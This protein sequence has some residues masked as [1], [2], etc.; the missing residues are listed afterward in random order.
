MRL[1]VTR[2]QPDG[3]R[4]A[5]LLR[6]QGHAVEIAPALRTEPVAARFGRG[7]FTALIMTSANA[8]R[9]AQ[10]HPRGNE[11]RALP[12][13]AVGRSSAETARAAGFAD[14]VSADGDV[15]DLAA[16]LAAQFAG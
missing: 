8:A 3:A 9:A 11:L 2:P 15:D 14:V 7:P 1:L 16:L 10:T 13:F 12:V 6:A 5:A 4:T